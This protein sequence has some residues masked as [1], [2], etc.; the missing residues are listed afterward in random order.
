MPL[1]RAI[2]AAALPEGDFGVQAGCRAAFA[3]A[4][5]NGTAAPEAA[6]SG[7]RRL[8][9][10]EARRHGVGS[11]SRLAVTA[12]RAVHRRARRTRR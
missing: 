7:G 10:S 12:D 1:V 8:R 9:R 11:R 2:A 3:G 6:S 5:R 4:W